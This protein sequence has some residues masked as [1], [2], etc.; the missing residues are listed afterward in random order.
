VLF[1]YSDESKAYRLFDPIA[2][3]IMISR[4]VMFDEG[5]S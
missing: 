2:K 3:K 4:D 1:G 5:E